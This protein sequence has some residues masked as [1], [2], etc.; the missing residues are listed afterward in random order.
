MGNSSYLLLGVDKGM[1]I[2]TNQANELLFNTKMPE[3]VF[4]NFK[5][6]PAYDETKTIPQGVYVTARTVLSGP[7]KFF[8]YLGYATFKDQLHDRRFAV[9]EDTIQIPYT[10]LVQVSMLELITVALPT[11]LVVCSVFCL[12]IGVAR[13]L[14][15]KGA[16]EN[17]V[18]RAIS[19]VLIFLFLLNLVLFFLHFSSFVPLWILRVHSLVFLVLGLCMIGLLVRNFMKKQATFVSII[20]AGQLLFILILDLYQF[21][22]I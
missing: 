2:M 13:L 20:L 6:N 9:K 11:V 14:L 17:W 10:D 21:W 15:K 22:R 16:A 4:G 8:R 7:G 3:V 1:V 18:A 5:E 19:Y 12:L